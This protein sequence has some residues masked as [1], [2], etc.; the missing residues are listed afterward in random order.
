MKAIAKNLLLLIIT[1]S[2]LLL[3]T[4]SILSKLLNN[5]NGIAFRKNLDG[6]IFKNIDYHQSIST[7]QLGLRSID[8]AQYP[9]HS[10]L[11]LG[12]SYTFGVGVN[13]GENFV[14]L[15]NRSNNEFFINA[16]QPGAGP[17]EYFNILNHPELTGHF[18]EVLI[19]VFANDIYNVPA[20][21][22][23]NKAL[24]QS[25]SGKEKAFFPH[26]SR[27]INNQSID[28]PLFFIETKLLAEKDSISNTVYY[29]WKNKIPQQF[30][31]GVYS[32]KYNRANLELG[33]LQKDYFETSF[34]LESEHA[35]QR[36]SNIQ[37]CLNKIDSTCQHH[38]YKLSICY[39]P[40]PLEY[41][42]LWNKRTNF[43]PISSLGTNINEKWLN[44]ENAFSKAIQIW[45]K[46]QNIP[47]LDLTHE[48]RK[49]KNKKHPNIFPH[50]L[51][52]N[53]YGHDIAFKA[54]KKWR[55]ELN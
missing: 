4:E 43:H 23:N 54:I 25:F 22:L 31:E 21:P 34:D 28:T 14:D 32:G 55:S 41:D 53:Q 8:T 26:L 50:D 39:I 46:Q 5:E 15:L 49:G 29:N 51:H 44:Q 19:C 40:S 2:L 6:Q 12:D 35:K 17:I 1:C 30:I 52:W 27:L 37:F 42:S 36:W 10:V 33:L 48:F 9:N 38:N 45:T 18:N 3:V 7:N 13:E 24:Y 47:F 11:V 20:Y 16:G